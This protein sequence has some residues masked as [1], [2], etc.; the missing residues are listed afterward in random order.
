MSSTAQLK[1]KSLKNNKN[2]KIN[3]ET[4]DN[5][6][7]GLRNHDWNQVT[8]NNNIHSAY[9]TL[10]NKIQEQFNLHIPTIRVQQKLHKQWTTPGIKKAEKRKENYMQKNV[11]NQHKQTLTHTN[12][13]KKPLTKSKDMRE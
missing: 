4:I 3:N 7:S 11:P 9:K 12:N 8:E 2:K 5:L 13:T 1:M 10:I 6:K